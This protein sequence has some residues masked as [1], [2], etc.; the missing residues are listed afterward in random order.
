M[1][2]RRRGGSAR[3]TARG[4]GGSFVKGTALTLG[5]GLGIASQRVLADAPMHPAA[6]PAPRAHDR[7]TESRR[8]VVLD[9]RVP[10]HEALAA[11][12]ARR[13]DVLVLDGATDPIA[14]IGRELAR[15]PAG[16]VHVVAHGGPGYVELGGRIFGAR[17]LAARRAELERWFAPAPYE[18]RPD[19]LVYGCEVARGARGEAFVRTLA[20]LTGADVGASTDLTG[21]GVAGGNWLL[22]ATI[23]QI[24][25]D[26]PFPRDVAEAFPATLDV[27][28]VTNLNDTGAG[29]L[30]AAIAAA[31]ANPGEDVIVFT[32]DP[33]CAGPGAVDASVCTTNGSVTGTIELAS[34]N[35]VVNSEIVVLGPGPDAL[36]IDGGDTYGILS[37]ASGGSLDLSGVTLTGGSG[38]LGGAVVVGF[39]AEDSTFTDVHFVDNAASYG[40]AIAINETGGSVV[41]DRCV[42]VGN[43][44][45]DGGAIHFA[46]A[47]RL[48]IVATTIAENDAEESGGAI[49]AQYAGELVIRD[50]TLSGNTGPS[51]AGAIY[52]W[53][54]ELVVAS[55]TISGNTGKYAGGIVSGGYAPGSI[56][57]CTITDNDA[58]T[59]EPEWPA[60]PGGI[61]LFEV[62][63]SFTIAGT[64]VAGNRSTVPGADGGS[65]TTAFDLGDDGDGDRQVA[66]LSN[67]LGEVDGVFATVDTPGLESQLDVDDP[68]LGP[69]T[70]NGGPTGTHALL[71]GSP[72]IDASL[73]SD[74]LGFV[75]F[76]NGL[77]ALATDQRGL[78]R[79]EGAAADVGAFELAQDEQPPAD[80][81]AGG[82]A[83]GGGGGGS[84]DDGCGCE[85][86]GASTGGPTSAVR[87][88][89][90]GA[91]GAALLGFR[92]RRRR[93]RAGD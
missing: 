39:S 14:A 81:G 30:R 33:A 83:G 26:L 43:S 12:A 76:S 34:G 72:A 18:R 64:I 69:L 32:S 15:R 68:G 35:L 10:N 3:S 9:S 41:L 85:V 82:G 6:P 75:G 61:A 66:L 37:V 27:F 54:T 20:D 63:D 79:V 16:E 28:A 38:W 31:A 90:L 74:V 55:S 8:L 52:A 73:P 78:P 65:V 58:V 17:E 77:G 51:G 5:V 50:S 56:I 21:G 25:A 86:A 7:A 19:L 44:A 24:E 46:N 45:N 59:T 47:A 89:L 2:N 29:S 53:G 88:G 40:G 67:V 62:N 84:S 57:Q 42:L 11:A 91:I 4:L 1:N 49:L 13:A 48:E 60:Y 23:G 93:A 70:D 22:E 80:A 87:T 92:A 71:A 36:A